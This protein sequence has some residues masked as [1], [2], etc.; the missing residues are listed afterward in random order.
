MSN[1]SIDLLFNCGENGRRMLEKNL[2]LKRSNDFKK[3]K[4]FRDALTE[5]GYLVSDRNKNGEFLLLKRVIS[6]FDIFF[7]IGFYEGVISNYVRKISDQIK[8]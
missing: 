4:K 5:N 6:K 7:D 8:I 3:T 2:C 1:L